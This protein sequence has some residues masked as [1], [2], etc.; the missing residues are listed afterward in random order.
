M[1]A[2]D[3]DGTGEGRCAHNIHYE[4]SL[5]SNLNNSSKWMILSTRARFDEI[6]VTCSVICNM[7]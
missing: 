5:L 6:H 1:L 2:R 3:R 7:S 4:D